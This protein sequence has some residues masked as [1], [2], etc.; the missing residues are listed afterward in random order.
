[1]VRTSSG[2]VAGSRTEGVVQLPF[3]YICSLKI[4]KDPAF[5]RGQVLNIGFIGRVFV[6]D[7][8]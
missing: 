8:A 3:T 6:P 5:R 2:E 1:M 7:Q 4:E